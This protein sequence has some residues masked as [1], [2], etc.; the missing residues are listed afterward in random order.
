MKN[1]KRKNSDIFND[2]RDRATYPSILFI[3]LDYFSKFLTE[4]ELK[5]LDWM[6]DRIVFAR[7]KMDVL[8]MD[9]NEINFDIFKKQNYLRENLF[10]L[11]D[12]KT[13]L[14]RTQFEFIFERYKDHILA[15]E[16]FF[17]LMVKKINTGTNVE[18]SKYIKIFEI[19]LAYISMHQK[20]FNEAFPLYAEK[21][22]RE[23]DLD[24]FIIDK[25]IEKTAKET[26][27][28]A[29][30]KPKEKL[31]T[32]FESQNFLL[33]TVFKLDQDILN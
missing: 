5:A 17:D 9:E 16:Y 8:F 7:A 6:F 15:M 26:P 25:I 3:P 13:D 19:Q 29:Y 12:L 27:K 32:D 33:K 21:Y 10:E 2:L 28:K 22:K 1:N 30:T 11:V 31:I 14:K 4:K 24:A 20:S 23:I 18:Y